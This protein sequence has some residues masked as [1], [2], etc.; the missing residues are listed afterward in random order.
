M[1]KIRLA[2]E[3]LV[4]PILDGIVKTPSHLYTGQEAVAVGLCNNLVQGDNIFGN[5]RSHGHYLA[6]GGDLKKM[7]AEIFC[8]ESGC[9]KGRGGSMHLIAPEHGV[10]GIVPIVA[11]TIALAL[12]SSLASKIKKNKNVTVSFFGDGATGEGVLFESLNFAS[13]KK[14]PIIFACENNLYSTHLP[15]DEI[16]SNL[17]ISTSGHP[18][19]IKSFS[20]DG[21]NI[22]DIEK[23]VLESLEYCRSGNGPILIEFKTYRMRGHVGPDDNIQGTHTDIRPKNEIKKWSSKDPI[24]N[25]E[26]YL[27]SE[28]IINFKTKDN[29]INQIN[30]EIKDALDFAMTSDFPN[31]KDLLKYVFK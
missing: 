17:D 10:Q 29:I 12:G 19:D 28:G 27:L 21:N 25:F 16:R 9:S 26:K 20:V 31:K 30:K 22:L 18:F 1:L 5:H 6:M 23:V 8:K 11:G 7:Y 2:E 15:I 24:I 4:K 3:A 14:L 13:L